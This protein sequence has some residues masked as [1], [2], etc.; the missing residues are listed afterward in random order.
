MLTPSSWIIYKN[1]D[2][3][4][5]IS[6]MA[7]HDDELNDLRAK[8]SEKTMEDV[9]ASQLADEE[10]GARRGRGRGTAT[11]AAGLPKGQA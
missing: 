9:P 10:E 1:G 5:N 3:L 4:R 11:E 2:R 8:Q 6:P 7:L